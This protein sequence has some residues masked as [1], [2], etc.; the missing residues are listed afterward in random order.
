MWLLLKLLNIDTVVA[1]LLLQ[2]VTAIFSVHL[3]LQGIHIFDI[4]DFMELMTVHSHE[5]YMVLCNIMHVKML[6]H[7]CGQA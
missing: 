1:T 6:H 4:D 5:M 2:R 7:F 3:L